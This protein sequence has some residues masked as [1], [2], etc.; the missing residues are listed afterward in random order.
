MLLVS[1][2]TSQCVYTCIQVQQESDAES[3]EMKLGNFGSSQSLIPKGADLGRE[4]RGRGRGGRST[5]TPRDET[6]NGRAPKKLTSSQPAVASAGRERGPGVIVEANS[7]VHGR[8]VSSTRG[9]CR[10]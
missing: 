9:V 5:D 2:T 10:I 3:G 8:E 4:A 7:P 6:D 1:G